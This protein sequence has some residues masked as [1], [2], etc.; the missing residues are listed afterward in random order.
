MSG[1]SLRIVVP[2]LLVIVGSVPANLPPA[3]AADGTIVVQRQ[4]Q[5][6]VAYRPSMVPDPHPTVVDTNVSAEVNALANGAASGNTVSRELGQAAS[7]SVPRGAGIPSISPPGGARRGCP[8]PPATRATVQ[9]VGNLGTTHGAG[10]GAGAGLAGQINGSLKQG[11]AP[12]QMLGGG[13]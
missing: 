11:L 7:P 13:Q 4:V 1:S 2:A 12:L 5:P 10:G 6:R 3:H 9:A 8:T